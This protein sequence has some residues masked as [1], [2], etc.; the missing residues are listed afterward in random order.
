M[1]LHEHQAKEILRRFAVP[2]PRGIPVYSQ[3]EARAAVRRLAAF[4]QAVKAQIHAGG[5]GKGGGVAVV[6]SEQEALEAAERI[7][8]MQLITPQTGPE[9]KQVRRLYIE[10]GVAITREFYLSLLV[11]RATARVTFIASQ[12]GGMNIEEVAAENP[13]AIARLPIPA[14][15]VSKSHGQQLAE[16]LGLEPGSAAAADCV[17]LAENLYRAFTESDLSLLEINPLG[18]LA[19]GR[20]CC[21]DAKISLD[22]NALFR[23]P[24]LSKMRD[25]SEENPTEMEAAA[26]GLNYI[27][28][29]GTIGCMVN[30]A[31]LAMATMDI[32]NLHGRAPANF[33]DVGGGASGERVAHAFRI[34]LSDANIQGILVNVFGGITRGDDI[35]RGIT[36]AA[37]EV[38]PQVPLV[39]RLAGTNA[40]EGMKILDASDLAITTAA[41]LEEAAQK[42]AALTAGA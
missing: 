13:E 3:D 22:D 16:A 29:D 9:G 31:G 15:G 27:Q 8:G 2:V 21:L 40:A 5:R 34:L 32:I 19:N 1:N 7:L 4:P 35:A 12:Q 42:I 41:D 6:G 28:L 25:T 36:A 26:H 10:E 17:S 24:D 18:L 23:Q 33:L 38:K 37:Q 39:V 11:D 30:G 14:A 20:L